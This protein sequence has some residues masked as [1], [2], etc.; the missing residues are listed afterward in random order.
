MQLERSTTNNNIKL[1]NSENE[2]KNC[3]PFD[4]VMM[5]VDISGIPSSVHF[6]GS[7]FVQHSV[8]IIIHNF[9]DAKN[10]R[11][12]KNFVVLLLQQHFQ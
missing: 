9:V 1:I 11:F 4:F 8:C 7:F 2:E 12:F 3:L 5:R 10:V 6:N